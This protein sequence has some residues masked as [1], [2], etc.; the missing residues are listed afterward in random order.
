MKTGTL[1]IRK[2]P[3]FIVLFASLTVYSQNWGGYIPKDISSSWSVTLNTGCLSYFGDLSKYDTDIEKKTSCESGL[4]LSGMVT[5]E[6][7]HC[8]DI[9]GQVL[10]GSLKGSNNG[11]SFRTKLLEYNLQSR[12]NFIDLLWPAKTHS[13]GL[14]GFVGIG[15][16]VFSAHKIIKSESSVVNVT[17][18]SAGPGFVF[19][20][21]GGVHFNA[22]NHLGFSVELSLRQYPK[23][24][25]D[26]LRMNHDSDYYSYFSA[27]VSY[28]I[29]SLTRPPLRNKARLANSS[30]R[31]R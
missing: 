21:G 22:T 17:E 31:F 2:S 18:Q 24:C 7:G 8:F 12:I 10:S 26:D 1:F 14:T 4:A 20:C 3:A 19:I 9:S 16:V 29:K 15:Q 27:G 30:C 28:F 13:F 5:K 11:T 6:I 25:I 23:D